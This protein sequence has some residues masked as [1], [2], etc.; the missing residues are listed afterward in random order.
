MQRGRRRNQPL[1]FENVEIETI[2]AEGKAIAKING[3]VIFIP[4]VAPGDIVDVIVT[5]KRK[6]FYEGKALKFH[7]YS[8]NRAKPFCQHFGTCG[9]CKW[10]HIPYEQQL[11]YKQTQVRDQL[12]RI[13]HV[14]VEEYKPIVASQ[15][16]TEYRNK[17]EFTFSAL[18]WTTEKPESMT[19]IELEDRRALGFHIPQRF[20]RVLDIEKCYLQAEPIN[21]I[22]NALK[23]FAKDKN[24]SFY[25]S[26]TKT[27]FLRNIM[28]RNTL[29]NQL[30]VVCVF[31]ENKTADI[32]QVMSFLENNFPEITSLHYMINLKQNDSF[33]NL[34][35]VS[36]SGNPFIFETLES[37]D[38]N[39]PNLKYQISPLSFFQTNSQQ[40]YQLYK[41][42]FDFAQFKGHEVVY[43]LYCG[44]GSISIF[45]SRNVK[46]VVGIEYVEQAVADAKINCEI[47]K[48]ENAE[49]FSGDIANVL[50][51]DFVEK[52]GIPDVIITDPP[53]S[54]MH[55]KVVNQILEIAPQRIIYVS[56][57]AATQAR[58]I[59]MLE[60]KYK[61]VAAQPVDMFP[62]THHIENVVLLEKKQ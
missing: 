46:K 55:P 37:P 52:N 58:D 30:M 45:I 29:D 53:R 25:N 54:G 1:I 51:N 41:T 31:G 43:D 38:K 61:A 57:N 27:G 39:F 13:G 60:S 59:Q 12:E 11:F 28:F 16:Q 8:E 15:R 10:Q 33:D 19:D 14:E 21:I 50:D 3:K 42:A 4:F 6:S 36:W 26:R 17:L 49:F 20:D 44:L 23:E 7:K 56:C 18:K 48:V 32:K 24:F 5:S 62:H 22:R 2:G 40:T 34:E 9:G 35:S 47:N